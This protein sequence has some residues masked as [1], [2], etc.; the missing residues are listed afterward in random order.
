MHNFFRLFGLEVHRIKKKTLI[1]PTI[2]LT[3]KERNLLWYV[4]NNKYLMDLFYKRQKS[5]F[6]E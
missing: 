3:E 1:K 6:N 5:N 4:I 2:D